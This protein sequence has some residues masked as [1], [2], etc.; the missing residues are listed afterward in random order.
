MK[1]QKP[2]IH[3]LS[4]PWAKPNYPSIQ[5]GALKAYIDSAIDGEA[6]CY[7]YSAYLNIY[8][9]AFGT[10]LFDKFYDYHKSRELTY[11]FIYAKNFINP[12]L[13]Y[14]SLVSEFNKHDIDSKITPTESIRIEEA[15][16][17]FIENILVPNLNTSAP[18]IIAFSLNYSQVYAS[19]CCLEYLSRYHRKLP[20]TF[21]IGGMSAVQPHVVDVLKEL[22][23]D[24]FVCA[25]EGEQ[26]LTKLLKEAILLHAG[27]K[28]KHL[29]KVMRS[30]EGVFHISDKVD[31]YNRDESLYLNQIKSIGGLPSPDYAEYF[32][33][34]KSLCDSTSAF[35]SL[36]SSISYLLIEG[37]RGCFA[38][39]DF[40]GLTYLWDGFRTKSSKEVL[41]S[42]LELISKH[43][44][45]AV[46]FVDNVTDAWSNRFAK[47]IIRSKSNIKSFLEIRANHPF[48]Y[49]VQL[50]LSGVDEV[51]IGIEAISA[52]LLRH[53]NKGTTVTQ[54]LRVHKYL[55]ELEIKAYNNLITHHVHS[56]L[57][58]IQETKR[59][60]QAT[61]HL[62]PF[63]LCRFGYQVGS[64][65][66][67]GLSGS[68]KK[69]LQVQTVFPR[70][71][72]PDYLHKYLI[73][74]LYEP[75]LETDE[76]QRLLTKEWDS[77][78]DWYTDQLNKQKDCQPFLRVSPYNFENCQF[79][80]IE[81]GRF[82]ELEVTKIYN[83]ESLIYQYCHDGKSEEKINKHFQLKSHETM[84]ILT[85]FINKKWM[86]KLDKDYLSIAIRPKNV[87]IN[88]FIASE[89]ED[90]I[91]R[92]INKTCSQA[93]LEE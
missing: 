2:A 1:P 56:E 62:R 19:L 77:F 90:R 36:K 49:W 29:S 55:Q 74:Y 88:E 65:L 41:S 7:A 69:N 73:D 81:D 60:L 54:N 15:T 75:T 89:Y 84:K 28:S 53:M 40:C 13:D 37:S 6:N 44:V 4:L 16:F 76:E 59:I 30:V 64:P 42:C 78:R 63:S 48:E 51:Q 79:S 68:Q 20:M 17:N 43:G 61:T 80:I 82:N 72:V 21:V 58:D 66:Y 50:Y 46:N 5:I 85:K 93:K 10:K 39:C 32:S 3:L 86:L 87:V 27:N 8:F 24:A 14:K 12:G 9:N 92:L 52:P 18:N 11:L 57:E 71:G 35:E 83:L 70:S 26:K 25:G 91:D 38:K 22:E 34:L 47:E 31:L 23:T 67:K 33:T 45:P